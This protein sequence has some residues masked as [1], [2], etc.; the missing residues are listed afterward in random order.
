MAVRLRAPDDS[1]PGAVI[2]SEGIVGEQVRCAVVTVSNS[3][4]EEVA[5]VEGQVGG[6]PNDGRERLAVR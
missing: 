2:L 3:Q 6:L 1:E 5:P 4:I